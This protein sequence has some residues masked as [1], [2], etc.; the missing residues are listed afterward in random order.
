MT[1]VD[2]CKWSPISFNR[3]LS[4]ENN[5]RDNIHNYRF[6]SQSSISEDADSSK[7]SRSPEFINKSMFECSVEGSK[8]RRSHTNSQK[9]VSSPLVSGDRI[10]KS[11]FILKDTRSHQSNK[12]ATLERKGNSDIT[13]HEDLIKAKSTEELKKDVLIKNEIK[14]TNKT[15]S[16][17]LKSISSQKSD[18][19]CITDSS[20]NLNQLNQ[21]KS[22]K[23]VSKLSFPET[24]N[25]EYKMHIS[26]DNA[27]SKLINHSDNNSSTLHKTSNNF[28]QLTNSNGEKTKSD[29]STNRKS[30]LKQNATLLPNVLRAVDF[31]LP[32]DESIIRPNEL[33]HTGRGV[34]TLSASWKPSML[35]NQE[36]EKRPINRK[37]RRDSMYEKGYGKLSSYKIYEKLGEGTYATVYK[38]YSLVSK[39]LVALK[40][41]RMKKSE[42]APC[43]AIREI[44]LLR[45]LNHANIV[46]LHD[47]IY[48]A[49]SL[50]L[51][52]EYGGND[53]KS[54]MRR[55]NNRLPMNIV[56]LFTFQIFRGLEYCHARQI[57]HRDLKPQNLLIGK[58]GDL[59][60]ADFGLA[61]S[62]SV[63]IRTYSSEVVT[64]WYRPPDVLLGDKNYSGHIDIWGVGC[65]LYEMTTGYSLFPGTSKEDQIKIIFRKFGIPP[66]SYW[67]NLRTNPKFLQYLNSNQHNEKCESNK[68]NYSQ[69]STNLNLIGSKKP[70]FQINKQ[71]YDKNVDS[72]DK[73]NESIKNTLSCSA[74]RLDLDGQQL[75]FECLALVGN[76]RI[77]ANDALKHIY[78][79]SIL[80]PGIN[81]H[82]LLP[83]QSI[84]LLAIEQN[85]INTLQ[86]SRIHTTNTDTTGKNNGKKHKNKNNYLT[87]LTNSI[88]YGN[89]Q[90][91]KSLTNLSTVR[92]YPSNDSNSCNTPTILPNFNNKL[93]TTKHKSEN[94]HQM[95]AFKLGKS[96][97]SIQLSYNERNNI[98]TTTTTHH[99]HEH[100]SKSGDNNNN[101]NSI[102]TD[103]SSDIDTSLSSNIQHFIP[104]EKVCSQKYQ[105]EQV[106]FSSL[107]K[108]TKL[109]EKMKEPVRKYLT[110]SSGD[111]HK[112]LYNQ[113]INGNNVSYNDNNHNNTDIKNKS[114]S[115]TSTT[116]FTA[117][118]KRKLY[119]LQTKAKA[120]RNR[121]RSLST[122]QLKILSLSS[123][124]SDSSKEIELI[125]AN[126]FGDDN[127]SNK[128]NSSDTFLN[129]RSVLKNKI[130]DRRFGQKT[131]QVIQL[132]IQSI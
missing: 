102:Q 32:T 64:L 27:D 129:S 124:S 2:V 90:L 3:F 130:N 125:H 104:Y 71:L 52:F 61:R 14:I 47:V 41:I 30:Y 55:H 98:S 53:L 44:S 20:D 122:D 24:R 105:P 60:L 4:H 50:T 59:K 23:M 101:N 31:V 43:T 22:Y 108:P 66:E 33:P 78:F 115:N 113:N 85:P 37:Q 21:K 77:T 91:S 92:S 89:E 57:L 6:G 70:S 86:Q 51:V 15:K 80:P 34:K 74:A 5:V 10:A 106:S 103:Q 100:E 9:V 132:N 49:G 35:H 123:P 116:N 40:R 126:D 73:Y 121:L 26:T 18:E 93:T 84:T 7:S 54:Y 83:E 111:V 38:G 11:V 81:V 48:E 120:S 29:K 110:I 16:N 127:N 69:S 82:D 79:K 62:Q 72:V 65:I 87:H 119:S 67:P 107:K 46:K 8:S 128:L 76:R 97:T 114:I 99:Q 118:V 45:G 25:I 96:K 112:I 13:T 75:L 42:G 95:Q 58:T 88:S 12:R 68:P 39:Q 131:D 63:P 109:N 117:F 94:Q 19:Y 1:K 17:Q 28:Y 56:R 36:K